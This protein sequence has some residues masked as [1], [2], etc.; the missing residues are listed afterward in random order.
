MISYIRVIIL[1]D[2][3]D[4]LIHKNPN[5]PKNMEDYITADD[6]DL[7]ATSNDGKKHVSASESTTMN[8]NSFIS[9]FARYVIVVFG[10]R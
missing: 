7:K 10:G 8:F 6:Y 2:K 5:H 1:L 4:G 9:V 3:L